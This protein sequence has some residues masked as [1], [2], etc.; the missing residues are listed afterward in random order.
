MEQERDGLVIRYAYRDTD[1]TGEIDA[2]VRFNGFSGAA[3]AWFTDEALLE[4]ARELLTYP[5]GAHQVRLSGGYGET[6]GDIEEH[7]G[8]TVGA[9]GGRGQIGVLTHLAR[10]TD[11]NGNDGSV[12][13]VRVEVFT[14]YEALGR[15]SSD[16]AR[17]VQ[18]TAAEAQLDAERLG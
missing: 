4:F 15:F 17:L 10:P 18:G 13:E 5:L 2:H 3:S 7:V 12:S 6:D 14:S 11:H 9:L 1:Q 16:L 8:L